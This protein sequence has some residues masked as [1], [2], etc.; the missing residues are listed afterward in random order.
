MDLHNIY[1]YKYDLQKI[2][3][4]YFKSTYDTTNIF[5]S[6]NAIVTPVYKFGISFILFTGSYLKINN[7]TINISAKFETE[8][9]EVQNANLMQ[10]SHLHS[11]ILLP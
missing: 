11:G 9:D 1:L 3:I 2:L 6:N 7:C 8:L 5:F 10:F 4:I